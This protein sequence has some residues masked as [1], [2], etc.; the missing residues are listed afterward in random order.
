M[1][2]SENK[3]EKTTYISAGNWY[4]NQHFY[5]HASETKHNPA[6]KYDEQESA[7]IIFLS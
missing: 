5:E 6:V 3:A 1:T 4:P 7:L 2:I